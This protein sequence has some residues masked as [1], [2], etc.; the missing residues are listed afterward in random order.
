MKKHRIL[1]VITTFILT[2][3]LTL[4]PTTAFAASS[5]T[6]NSTNVTLYGL[7]DTY[8]DCLTLPSDYPVSFQFKVN[9][10]SSNVRWSKVSGDSVTITADGLVKPNYMT[11]YWTGNIGSTFPS[12]DPNQRVTH[13]CVFGESVISAIVDGQTL[14]ATVNVNSYAKEYVDNII[15]D[16]IAKNIPSTM[17]DMEKL[18][19][20]CKLVASYDYSPNS[21]FYIPMVLKNGGDCWA[22]VSFVNRVCEKLN[23]PCNTRY[24]VND[25]GA[26]SGHRNNVVL[27]DGKTY[28]VDV[29]FRGH[30]PRY[31][32]ITE[33]PDGFTFKT[34]STSAT[35]TQY[36]GFDS[37]VSIP[38]TYQNKPVETIAQSIFFYN[39]LYNEN[40]VT[41]VTIPS[42]VTSISPYAFSDLDELTNVS[43]SPNNSKYCDINGVVYTKDKKQIVY[44]PNGLRGEY[45]VP[46]GVTSV[47]EYSF[48][49]SERLT[50]VKLPSG[51][52]TLM[53]G[54]FGDCI[55]LSS[56]TLPDTLTTIEDFAFYNC[57]NLKS[58]TIPKG[59]TTISEN[60]FNALTSNLT[61]YGYSGSAAETFATSKGYT[62]VALKDIL[63]G[64]ANGDGDINISDATTIQ[65]YL[66]GFLS[67]D[68]INLDYAD[69]TKDGNIAIT[70]ATAI[71]KLCAGIQ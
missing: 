35:L 6:L 48:Y 59:V 19:Q 18:Q 39:Q 12:G 2:A 1:C 20:V 64:D 38:E 45:T 3:I 24:A 60:A 43:V 8:S 22:S 11:Y 26:G 37:E 33:M 40:Y 46:S 65:K 63:Y 32:E 50:S 53:A 57:H 31:Y 69:M 23:I 52:T 27:V 29:G 13:E 61:I 21:S 71:Q 15:D 47:G 10:T 5:P 56:I 49:Y 4:T 30:A 67:A 34:T 14:L 51:V 41:K 68:Q 7:D 66:V 9:G 55:N 54:A 17:T 58:I 62:F 70:D 25:V 36:D 16:Y 28:M 42:T 44:Y